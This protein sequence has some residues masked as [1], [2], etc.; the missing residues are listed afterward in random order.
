MSTNLQYKFFFFFKISGIQPEPNPP[1]GEPARKVITF[2]PG[3]PKW[4]ARL[5][6]PKSRWPPMSATYTVSGDV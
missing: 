5:I 4:D 1:E 3:E 6:L 2:K